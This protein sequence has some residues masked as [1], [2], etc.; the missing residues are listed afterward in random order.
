[1]GDLYIN[2]TIVVKRDR[3]TNE[4]DRWKD[5]QIRVA[6]R[7]RFSVGKALGHPWLQDFQLWCDLRE[8]EKK[9]GCWYLTHEG[10]DE[11]WRHHAQERGLVFPSHLTWTPW[12]DDSL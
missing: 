9:M 7:R 10:D 6:V 8:F 5:H 11:R 4:D 2:P 3:E 1:M 12:Q